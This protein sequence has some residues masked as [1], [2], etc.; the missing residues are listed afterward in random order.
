MERWFGTGLLT[1]GGEKWRSRRK[2]LT[3]AFH[4]NTLNSFVVVHDAEAQIMLEQIEE[5]ASTGETF[6]LYPYVKR[7]TLDIICGWLSD[8]N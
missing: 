6:D 5:F 8:G 2:L 3:P 1:S 7:L 4:F